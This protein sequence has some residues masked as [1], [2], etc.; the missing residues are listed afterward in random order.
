LNTKRYKMNL[1]RVAQILSC[2]ILF[3]PLASRRF[4]FEYRRQPVFTE[5]RW[6][7]LGV[8]SCRHRRA[9]GEH[10][11]NIPYVLRIIFFKRG[12][13]QNLN[14]RY[15]LS[16]YQSMKVAICPPPCWCDVKHNQYTRLDKNTWTF[17][18][19]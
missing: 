8:R 1:N 15:L 6:V 18:L 19:L 10:F 9:P 16:F 13:M 3:T 7:Y 5:Y 2:F 12:L 14:L 17:F 11:S 4:R